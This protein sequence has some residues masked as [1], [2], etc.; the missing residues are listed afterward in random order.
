MDT[1]GNLS[2]NTYLTGNRERVYYDSVE[3]T[4]IVSTSVDVCSTIVLVLQLVN[5]NTPRRIK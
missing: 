5:R 1:L 3:L 2:R 4:V